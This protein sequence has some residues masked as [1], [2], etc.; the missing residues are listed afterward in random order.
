MRTIVFFV[1]SKIDSDR[2]MKSDFS[3]WTRTASQISKIRG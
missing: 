1:D 2:Q 3:R